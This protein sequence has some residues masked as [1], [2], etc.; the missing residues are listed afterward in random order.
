MCCH[1][2]L[3]PTSQATYLQ[4]VFE[5]LERHCPLNF[6]FSCGKRTCQVQ[7]IQG[8]N[9]GLIIESGQ[10]L[11]YVGIP[12]YVH[13]HPR[14]LNIII[15]RSN[16]AAVISMF[17]AGLPCFP[18]IGFIA[19][20]ISCTYPG[21]YLRHPRHAFRILRQSDYTIPEVSQGMQAVFHRPIG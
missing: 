14:V 7:K 9:H 2:I 3:L 16:E 8:M 1:P 18:W 19:V 5:Q 4:I 6:D 15:I 20:A 17:W 13:V 12:S 21:V 10:I 11:K